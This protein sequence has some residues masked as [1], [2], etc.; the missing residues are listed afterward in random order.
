MLEWLTRWYGG[1]NGCSLVIKVMK[2]EN[3]GYSRKNDDKPQKSKM[4]KKLNVCITNVLLVFVVLIAALLI[5]LQSPDSFI[6]RGSS[7]T[8]S[9]VFQYIGREILQGNIPYRDTFDHKGPLIYL[10]NSLGLLISTDRGFWYLEIVNMFFAMWF[11]LKTARI[12]GLSLV[13]AF[14][15]VIVASTLLLKFFEGGN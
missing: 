3:R 6:I 8:D 10:I 12:A 4:S 9:S 11:M 7:F 13:Q 15:V 1:N 2:G 5:C 14:T